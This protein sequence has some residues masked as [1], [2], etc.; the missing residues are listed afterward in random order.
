MKI[1]EDLP[2]E[3]PTVKNSIDHKEDFFASLP[4]EMAEA[5]CRGLDAPLYPIALVSEQ[6]MV[7]RQ[8]APCKNLLEENGFY[9]IESALAPEECD[10]IRH[11]IRTNTEQVLPV[12]IFDQRWDIHIVPREGKALLIF[13]STRQIGINMAMGQLRE[14]IGRLLTHAS[15]MDL[16]NLKEDANAVRQEALRILRQ[17][18]HAEMLYGAAVPAEWTRCSMNGILETAGMQLEQRGIQAN[19]QIIEPDVVFRADERLLLS[20][21]M[22]LISNSL[23]HGG[24]NVHITIS[25]RRKNE[26]VIF[27]V[28]DDGKGLSEEAIRNM[29]DAWK[30]TDA[31]PGGWGLGVPYARHIAELHGGSLVFASRSKGC[32]VRL[33]I[34]IHEADVWELEADN[35]YPASPISEADIELSYVLE[36]GR[37]RKE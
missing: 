28:D 19:V 36:K 13:R 1:V 6:L 3:Q 30:K 21:L 22:T 10:V 5:I 23:R 29:N 2:H 34:P 16:D 12:R 9:S 14:S 7:L 26:Y 15:W 20:A 11:C 18:N 25:A 24:E 4:P 27:S 31:F 33:S 37:F 8:T 17:A 35:P 32:A